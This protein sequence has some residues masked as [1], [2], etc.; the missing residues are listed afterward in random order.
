MRDITNEIYI[1][2][3]NGAAGNS[4]TYETVDSALSFNGVNIIFAG[5]HFMNNIKL[6]SSILIRINTLIK[7]E[8]YREAHRIENLFSR[9]RKLL[10]KLYENGEHELTSIPFKL[11]IHFQYNLHLRT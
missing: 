5:R 4:L 11:L 6:L 7:S 8:E 1:I 9:K 10:G 3:G 2:L